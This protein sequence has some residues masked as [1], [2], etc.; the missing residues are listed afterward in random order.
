VFENGG[1]KD[2]LMNVSFTCSVLRVMIS[3]N[4]R[5]AEKNIMHERNGKTYKLL[6]GTVTGGYHLGETGVG[7][8]IILEMIIKKCRIML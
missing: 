5:C 6:V 3:R 2:F 8:L 1:G 7:R 4:V